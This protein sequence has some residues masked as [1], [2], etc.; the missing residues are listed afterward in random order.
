[1]QAVHLLPAAVPLQELS[2]FRL[3]VWGG[4]EYSLPED[5]AS[6][7]KDHRQEGA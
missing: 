2:L 3:S 4:Q 7:R 6:G 1:M 5:A